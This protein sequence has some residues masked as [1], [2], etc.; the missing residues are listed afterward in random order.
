LIIAKA[1]R[2]LAVFYHPDNRDTGNKDAFLRVV[3]AYRTLSD[4]VR[5]TTYDRRT[6][7]NTRAGI[8][9]LHDR[10]STL[11]VSPARVAENEGELRESILHALYT[12]RRNRPQNPGLSLMTLAELVGC[13][14]DVMQFTLWYLRGKKLIEIVDDG[15]VAITVLGVDHIES[16]QARHGGSHGM[17]AMEAH[18]AEVDRLS[19]TTSD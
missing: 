16:N 13:S 17:L 19:D 11:R 18:Q 1:Y 14:I 4:P 2:L 5:R 7:G 10:T 3:E 9:E 6:F 15:N 8:D 12:T